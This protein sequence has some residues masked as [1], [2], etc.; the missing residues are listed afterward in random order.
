MYWNASNCSYELQAD[1]IVSTSL[2][3]GGKYGKRLFD[4]NLADKLQYSSWFGH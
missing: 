4:K 3:Y 2:E 1:G